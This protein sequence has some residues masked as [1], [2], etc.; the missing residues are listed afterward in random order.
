MQLKRTR[1]LTEVRE[2]KW[3]KEN[4]AGHEKEFNGVKY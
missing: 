1:V 4:N 3:N 2:H